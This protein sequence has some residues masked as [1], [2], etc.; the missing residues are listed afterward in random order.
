MTFSGG[1]LVTNDTNYYEKLQ[2]IRNHAEAVVGD[3]GVSDIVNMI[4]YNFRLGEIE[5]AI[6]I[7]QLKKLNKF[8]KQ[9]QDIANKLTIGLNG[10]D[11][12]KT[13]Y[14]DN[15]NTHAYYMYPLVLDVDKL[16]ISRSKICHALFA[17]G[18]NVSEGYQNIHLLPMF[19]SKIAY[20]SNGFPWSSDIYKGNVK[21]D[22]GICP[23]AE[24]FHDTSLFTIGLCVY[25]LNDEDI[26]LIV[27]AFKKV[28]NNLD[29]LK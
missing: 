1:I 23:I 28:W 13:P 16:Q 6:G 24:Q 18:I 14:V 29:L 17:E 22:K 11:G 3:K 7:E 4:G 9:R 8:V 15:D 21:Y 19:Q 26:D 5:S 20:G 27:G 25:D 12:L 10:L 2:L